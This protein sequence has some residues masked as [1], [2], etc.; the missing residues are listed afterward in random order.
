MMMY[1]TE[2]IH[3]MET[4]ANHIVELLCPWLLLFPG[5]IGVVAGII[6]ILFQVSI[7]NNNPN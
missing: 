4:I 2:I 6:Q 5:S 1:S 3:K 7:F